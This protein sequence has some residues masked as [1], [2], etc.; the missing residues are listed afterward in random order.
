MIFAIAVLAGCLA[1]D[2]LQPAILAVLARG[3]PFWQFV[4]L[5]FWQVLTG[6]IR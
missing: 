1:Q 4:Y 6:Q 2:L 5:P 3:L